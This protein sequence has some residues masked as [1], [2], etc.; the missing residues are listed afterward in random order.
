MGDI[1]LSINV[2]QA[3]VQSSA[4]KNKNVFLYFLK[5]ILL[6]NNFFNKTFQAKEKKPDFVIDLTRDGLS[7]NSIG[8]GY[9]YIFLSKKSYMGLCD[10]T[11]IYR[12]VNYR[13]V[14]ARLPCTTLLKTHFLK[15]HSPQALATINFL[16]FL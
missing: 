7:S 1:L 14:I 10:C 6:L 3:K 9:I 8:K 2:Y 4:L 16:S 5:K 13:I 12:I 11:R 15:A